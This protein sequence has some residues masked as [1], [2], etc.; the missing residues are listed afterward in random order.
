MGTYR[1]PG[2][3]IDPSSGAINEAIKSFDNKV[4][5]LFKDLNNQHTENQVKNKKLQEEAEIDK[6]KGHREWQKAVSSAKPKKGFSKEMTRQLREWGD[7]YYDLYGSTDKDD[8]DRMSLLLT[9]PE[10]IAKTQGVITANMN[11][12][13]AANSISNNGAGAINYDTS[14]NLGLEIMNDIVKNNG[15]NFDLREENGQLI[16]S[17]GGSDIN[18]DELVKYSETGELLFDVN[19]DIDKVMMTYVNGD[20]KSGTEGWKD[21]IDY[22]KGLK[23]A[24]RTGNQI[25]TTLDYDELNETL[26][27]T[28]YASDM[29]GALDDASLMKSIWPQLVR[30]AETNQPEL[31]YGPDGKLGGGDDLITVNYTGG[32]ALWF[33]G[34]ANSVNDEQKQVA[35][36]IMIER[37]FDPSLASKYGIKETRQTASRPAPSGSSKNKRPDEAKFRNEYTD[38]VLND[39]NVVFDNN[40]VMTSYDI[41]AV[42]DLLNVGRPAGKN[43]FYFTPQEVYDQGLSAGT[44]A[45]QAEAD[46]WLVDNSNNVFT[47]LKDIKAILDPST[48]DTQEELIE[49]MLDTHYK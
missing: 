16:W 4:N 8:L 2:Q 14:W 49:L 7:E 6:L 9:Y 38:K 45:N 33:S 22:D 10:E 21:I 31:I 23:I 35:K 20:R 36:S 48:W 19:G 28:A 12:Y 25:V 34:Q 46:Q 43:R 37:M 32:S 24:Q 40:G 18:N 27:Q 47:K 39:S 41:E 29:S 11:P 26:K 13:M 5:S 30:W 3:I 17:L 1:Q 44:F 42:I 15:D